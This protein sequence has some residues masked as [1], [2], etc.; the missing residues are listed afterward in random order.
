MLFRRRTT[1]GQKLIAR[2]VFANLLLIAGIFSYININNNSS[3][4]EPVNADEWNLSLSYKDSEVN[5]GQTE[6]TSERITWPNSGSDTRT[7]YF[8]INYSAQD[9]SRSYAPGELSIKLDLP[10][11][12]N[13]NSTYYVSTPVDDLGFKQYI[14]TIKAQNHTISATPKGSQS[15]VDN[16]WEYT[17]KEKVSYDSQSYCEFTNTKEIEKSSSLE[18]TIALAFEVFN[19]TNNYGV[20]FKDNVELLYHFDVKAVL[21]GTITSNHATFDCIVP[22]ETDWKKGNYSVH[23]K[24]QK[25]E[26]Y[27]G[28]GSNAQDYIWIHY[29]YFGS[30]LSEWNGVIHPTSSPYETPYERGVTQSSNYDSARAR[31]YIPLKDWQ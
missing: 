11:S 18:G 16:D 15:T 6:M 5:D 20:M 22:I 4:Y 1:K 14:Q 27:D 24:P 8:Q 31:N 17:C 3:A 19:A 21:N 29:T 13:K 10:F 30:P 28:L 25:I 26:S 12:T 2:V 7:L 23:L 9:L